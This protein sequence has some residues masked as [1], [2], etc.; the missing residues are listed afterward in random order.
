MEMNVSNQDFPIKTA[1]VFEC[2]FSNLLLPTNLR[3]EISKVSQPFTEIIDLYRNKIPPVLYW[4]LK[5]EIFKLFFVPRK[6]IH[7]F[8]WS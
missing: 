8:W 7:A 2:H 1:D 6:N 3:I 5:G 4:F